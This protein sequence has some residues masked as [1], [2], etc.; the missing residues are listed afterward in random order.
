MISYKI[1]LNMADVMAAKSMINKQVFPLLNQA[2][3]AVAT[4][5]AANWQM[6][7][8]KQRG[9]WSGE[10]D[11]YAQTISFEML[12]D[13]SAIVQATYDQA[14]QIESGRPGRDLKKM[15][16]TSRKVRRTE[17][18]RRFLV[19][20]M[21][22]NM[23]GNNALAQSMPPGVY[24]MA[25]ALSASRVTAQTRRLAGEVTHLDPKVGMH[26]STK[27]TD[28]LSNT[29][30]KSAVL[31]KR[32]HYEWGGQLKASVLKAAGMSAADVKRYSGMRKFDN[33]TLGAPSSTYMTF[34]LMVEG[35]SGWVTKAEP[36][37]YIAK[38]VEDDMR[39]LAEKAFQ[40]AVK[41]T[42]K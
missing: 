32:N 29:R 9:M 23:T 35:S 3:R 2:V 39:P 30:T 12:D 8:Y 25:K 34:R 21:R 33:G 5:L 37:R 13:F 1:S 17:D 4:Q 41:R 6:E 40:E 11:A 16:D 42:L 10:K 18:G 26:A 7:V 19:I 22:H 36:G 14:S 38:K 24:A 15:L 28:Y 27:Q 31:V 20:P